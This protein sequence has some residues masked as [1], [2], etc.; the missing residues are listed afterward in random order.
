MESN[1]KFPKFVEFLNENSA[2]QKTIGWDNINGEL[3]IQLKFQETDGYDTL[4]A[5]S[6]PDA[7]LKLSFDSKDNGL[8]FYYNSSNYEED[9]KGLLN[10][11]K[12]AAD[13]FDKKVAKI[14]EK[15]NFER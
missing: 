15:R 6:E 5:V 4:K 7:E 14:L 3:D 11:L 10:D 1:K 9:R 12:E 8:V 2:D 13:E